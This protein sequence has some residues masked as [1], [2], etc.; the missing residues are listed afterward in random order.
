MKHF[1]YTPAHKPNNAPQRPS[2]QYPG[3][4]NK[5]VLYGEVVY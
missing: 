1:I 3:S 2:P 4:R 5:L